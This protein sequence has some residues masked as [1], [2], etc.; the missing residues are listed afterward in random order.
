MENDI[1][2]LGVFWVGFF[3]FSPQII[4]I[5][6]VFRGVFFLYVLTLLL[7][8]ETENKIILAKLSH[9][10]YNNFP[11]FIG[12]FYSRRIISH[13]DSVSAIN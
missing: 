11:Y 1:V 8:T 3:F 9:I 12:R 13:Q 5:A 4:Q 7:N 2:V 6:A 10:S